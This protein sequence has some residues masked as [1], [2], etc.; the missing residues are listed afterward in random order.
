MLQ[1]SGL[2]VTGLDW[3]QAALYLALTL[4]RHD[5][6]RAELGNLLPKWKKE[7]TATCAPP[8]ITTAEVKG[9]LQEEHKDWNKSLFHPPTKTPTKEE[10]K[11]MVGMVLEQAIIA[12]MANTCYMFDGVI[13]QQSAGLT[14]FYPSG[15]FRELMTRTD[16]TH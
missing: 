9:P 5:A 1:Q 16:D 2:E 8:G 10:M 3:E 4:S 13:R 14:G 6:R 12:I 15:G 11:K 7:K